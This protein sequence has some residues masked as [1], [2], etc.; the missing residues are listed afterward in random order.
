MELLAL[1]ILNRF[2]PVIYSGHKMSGFH[3]SRSVLVKKHFLKVLICVE[4]GIQS[5]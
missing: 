1:V 4:N 3:I 2:S 5:F